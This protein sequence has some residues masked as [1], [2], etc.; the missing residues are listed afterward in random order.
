MKSTAMLT[1]DSM[2]WSPRV[3][4]V[5][6]APRACM[7]HPRLRGSLAPIRPLRTNHRDDVPCEIL[8]VTREIQ[9]D[10]KRAGV[11]DPRILQ[12]WRWWCISGSETVRC[13]PGHRKLSHVSRSTNVP[14]WPVSKHC[15]S[16]QMNVV[17]WNY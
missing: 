3:G 12:Q 13:W 9:N 10:P 15:H 5:S 6:W 8:P 14:Q 2:I 16:H 1:C 17:N 7:I 11:N 4:P